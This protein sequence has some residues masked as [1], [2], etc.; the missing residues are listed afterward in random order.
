[1]VG[2]IGKVRGEIRIDRR[3]R[4]ESDRLL[5]LPKKKHQVRITGE[6]QPCGRQINGNGLS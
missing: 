2:T 6:P 3:R 1:M 5:Q 4:A